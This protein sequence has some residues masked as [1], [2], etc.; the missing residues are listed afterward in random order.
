MV[1][2]YGKNLTDRHWQ[3]DGETDQV[4]H[5]KVCRVSGKDDPEVR[6]CGSGGD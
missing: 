5:E 4:K 1:S 6:G 2:G 3:T